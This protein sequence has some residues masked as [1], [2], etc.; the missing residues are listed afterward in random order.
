MLL[1]PLK[2]V[3]VGHN[4]YLER[5]CKA[6]PEHLPHHDVFETPSVT[7]FFQFY[8]VGGGN[9]E[10][11]EL[12]PGWICKGDVPPDSVA[13]VHHFVSGYLVCGE[14]ID[15]SVLSHCAFPFWGWCVRVPFGGDLKRL[16]DPRGIEL[17][18]DQFYEVGVFVPTTSEQ[19]LLLEAA[20]CVLKEFAVLFVL[21]V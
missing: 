19:V 16:H 17:S 7:E 6:V 3:L 20:T 10:V 11:L 21:E 18:F 1:S 2:F 15:D 14:D 4:V 9:C 8:V 5:R 12:L 13:V